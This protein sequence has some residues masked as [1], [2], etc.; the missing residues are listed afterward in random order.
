MLDTEHT[1]LR[2]TFAGGLALERGKVR[3]IYR[4]GDELVLVATDRLS[5]F[6]R[7]LG[8]CPTRAQLLNRSPPGGS[9]RL[10]RPRPPP[11][12]GAC[13]IPN[14]TVAARCR[15]CPVEVV[16]R[17][18]LTGVT[19]TSLWPRYQPGERELYGLRLPDGLSFNDPLPGP[20]ITPTTK[21]A[22]RPARR[23]ADRAEVVR[24]GLVA[25]R[26]GGTQVAAGGAGPVRAGASSPRRAA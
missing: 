12:A 10:G 15:P 1:D 24:R 13:P 25:R 6:D 20:I 7:V 14:V 16:V 8:L 5:A 18:Y 4:L 3:D 26:R 9:S 11:P 2:G 22:G 21:A 17:G 19:S 23:A